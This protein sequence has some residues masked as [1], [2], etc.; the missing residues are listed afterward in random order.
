MGKEEGGFVM[1]SVI[2]KLVFGEACC[3]RKKEEW[4]ELTYLQIVVWKSF[5]YSGKGRKLFGLVQS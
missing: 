4:Q 3:S 1:G 5:A 2:L